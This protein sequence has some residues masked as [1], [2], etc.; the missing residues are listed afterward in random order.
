MIDLAEQGPGSRV[1]LD[2]VAQRQGIS[3]KYLEVV[4]KLLVAAKLVR[5]VSGKGGGYQLL[6]EPREYT[7]GEVLRAAEGPLSI[8][9]CLEE[10]AE[11]C[12]REQACKTLAMWQQFDAMTRAFFG[13]ITLLDLMEGRHPW[14]E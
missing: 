12:P 9:A 14:E 6:R 13:G 4:V 3:K 2:D 7:V 1:R 11:P 5:G 8:V 10:G